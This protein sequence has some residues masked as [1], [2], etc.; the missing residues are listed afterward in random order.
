MFTL[1]YSFRPWKEAKAIA[2]GPSI[3]DY[4]RE[5][6]RDYGV[7]DRIRYGRRVVGAEW[8]TAEARWSVEIERT[9]TGETE[10]LTCGFLF[11]CTGYYRYDEGYT[12]EFAGRDDFGGPDRP[13][14]ALARGPRLRRQAGGRDRQRRHRRD[15]DP[16]RWPRRPHT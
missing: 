12:P 7:E 10:R 8:S 4:I 6:A 14:S 11:V 2:D 5:T 16:R 1:G 13:P 3:L 15:P 9:D